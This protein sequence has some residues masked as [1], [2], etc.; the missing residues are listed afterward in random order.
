MKKI[1][2]VVAATRLELVRY[3]YQRILSPLRLP[4]PPNRHKERPLISAKI[5]GPFSV[6]VYSTYGATLPNLL[7]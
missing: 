4:I 6:E 3:Y 7:R 2:L 1:S 5:L